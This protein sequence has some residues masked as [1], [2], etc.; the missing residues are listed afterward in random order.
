MARAR[1]DLLGLGKITDG[2][3]GAPVELREPWRSAAKDREAP[4][5]RT[6]R[7][8]GRAGVGPGGVDRRQQRRRMEEQGAH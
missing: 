2:A 6:A 4:F 3:S 1:K 8:F 7:G 5:G